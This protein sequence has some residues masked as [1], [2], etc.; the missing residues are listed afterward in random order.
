MLARNILIETKKQDYTTVASG[1][2]PIDLTLDKSRFLRQL[3]VFAYENGIGEGVDITD[4]KLRVNNDIYWASKWGDLQVLNAHNSAL[5]FKWD[6]YM[7]CVGTTDELW[8]RIPAPIPLMI[9]GTAP[10]VAPYFGTLGNG[11]KVTITT[12]AANDVNL[13][14]IGS[15]VLPATAI[16]DFDMDGLF[17]NLQWAGVGDLDLVLTNGGAGG[18]VQIIEQH[19]AKPW[20][21]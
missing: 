10:T 7:K 2:Q 17:Q 20:G 13:I 4:M 15:N 21:Y 18:A 6:L 9:A 12:D 1:D 14:R 16:F 3:L 19:V 5:D 8:T 11:D